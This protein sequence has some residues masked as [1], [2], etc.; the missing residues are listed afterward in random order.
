[1]TFLIA[2]TMLLSF[3]VMKDIHFL[4]CINRGFIK[5]NHDSSRKK[6]LLLSNIAVT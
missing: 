6:A 4:N 5:Y 3:R 2:F 1:M